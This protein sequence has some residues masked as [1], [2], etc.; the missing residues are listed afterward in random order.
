MKIIEIKTLKDWQK[1]K[2]EIK[3][4]KEIILFKYSPICSLSFT[5]GRIFEE[6]IDNYKDSENFIAAK[7]NVI[8]SREVSN[9][10]ET[11]TGI[12][13]QSPQIIWIDLNWEV[14]W[15]ES[16]IGITESNLNKQLTLT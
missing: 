3:N 14:K 15:N 5:A 4:N 12:I 8:E 9:N 2:S 10:V 7:I 16:H 1:I 13:H 11:E 6:W